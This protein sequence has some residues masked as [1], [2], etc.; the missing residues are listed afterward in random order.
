MVHAAAM[1][2]VSKET[3]VAG[4]YTGAA[5]NTGSEVVYSV[6]PCDLST[7]S[8]LAQYRRRI[9]ASG[10]GELVERNEVNLRFTRSLNDK[11]SAG[12]GARAYETQSLG[13]IANDTNYVQLHA[14]LLWQMTDAFSLRANYR[15]TVIDRAVNGESADSNRLTLW[16]TYRPNARSQITFQPGRN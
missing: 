8:K 9:S 1:H 14:Q 15:H 6:S 4:T 10:R 5:V 13:S 3:V 12:L 7:G 16:F 2:S 11:F